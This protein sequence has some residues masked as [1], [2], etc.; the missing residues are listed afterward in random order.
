MDMEINFVSTFRWLQVDAAPGV[1]DLLPTISVVTDSRIREAKLTEEF[2]RLAGE[3]EYRHLLDASH[4]L[5]CKP[6]HSSAFKDFD[7][8]E[9]AL[10]TWLVWLG[11]LIEDSWL[12]KDNCIGCEVAYC[13]MVVGGL[14]HWTNNGIYSTLTTA[15]GELQQDV[16]FSAEELAEWLSI[17]DELRTLKHQKGYSFQYSPVSKESSRFDRFLSFIHASRTV[18]YP[19]L[20]I[21]HI[22]S[23]LESLF[24]TTTTELTHRLSERVAF[25]LGGDSREMEERYQFMKK[26]YG[27]RSQ[28]THGS[29]IKHSD[30]EA[31]P[32]VS[33]GL[34]DLCR[35][36]V[37]AILRDQ[38]KQDL[39]YGSNEHIEDYFRRI[40]FS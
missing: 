28:V 36:I 20:K 21:A 1:Y 2:K 26:A 32:Q 27:I 31:A 6:E 19:A 23:A 8:S 39:V 35:K 40:L 13:N 30:L 11:W 5:I 3:I 37:F 17:T 15:K 10:L 16:S 38:E 25:F 33:K 12:V 14:R 34:Q 4:I 7:H 9:P 18:P 22:C 29:H 24:S